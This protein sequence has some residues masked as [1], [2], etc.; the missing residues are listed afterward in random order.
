ME[1]TH[2]NS[3]K[4]YHRLKAREFYFRR[5]N[6]SVDRE[7]YNKYQKEYRKKNIKKVKARK[8]V[9]IA[10]RNGTLIK[11]PCEKCGTKKNVHAHHPDYSKPLKVAWVCAIHHAELSTPKGIDV[12]A[13]VH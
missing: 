1:V 12:L 13:L 5:K 9:F 6:N 7:K 3:H 10:L 2:K 8:A 11:K 4:I